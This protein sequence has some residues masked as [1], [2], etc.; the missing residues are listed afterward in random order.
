MKMTKIVRYRL[1]GS[2]AFGLLDETGVRRLR[3]DPWQD[4]I[5]GEVVASL[6]QV[7]LL[8]PCQPTKIV[9]VGLNYASHAAEL[10][11]ELPGFADRVVV[12]CARRGLCDDHVARTSAK[13]PGVSV[14]ADDLS[15]EQQALLDFHRRVMALRAAQP[16][17]SH[18]SRQHLASSISSKF[19]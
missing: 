2:V 10:G 17:L 3:S 1:G 12:D 11:D 8:A 15:S 16:A 9:A 13:V 4:P 5:P 18:G 19:G 7:E 6:D 14:A